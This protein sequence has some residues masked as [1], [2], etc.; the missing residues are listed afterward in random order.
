MILEEENL[1]PKQKADALSEY[2]MIIPRVKN[3]DEKC[4]I[5]CF[6][7][8]L[9][10]LEKC[11][12]DHIGVFKESFSDDHLFIKLKIIK[13]KTEL[14]FTKIRLQKKPSEMVF[15]HLKK[16]ITDYES[17]AIKLVDE[18][19]QNDLPSSS[20]FQVGQLYET[21]AGAFIKFIGYMIK[22]QNYFCT[23]Q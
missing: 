12:N 14:L 21:L 5:K 6:E 15:K 8:H 17:D 1:N 20:Q 7:K 9:E 10:M 4:M 2:M 16:M 22:F 18:E 23:N 13:L 11:Y 19:L 3:T